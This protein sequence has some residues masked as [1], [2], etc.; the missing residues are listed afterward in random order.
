MTERKSRGSIAWIV[1][2]IVAVICAAAGVLFV[3]SAKSGFAEKEAALPDSAIST[4][5][6]HVKNSDYESIYEDSLQVDPTL[7]SKDDYIAKIKEIYSGTNTDSITYKQVDKQTVT[8]YNL[9]VSDD[10]LATLKL[11]QDSDGKWL[12]STMFEGDTS[13]TVEVPT[14]LSI[15]VNG[16]DVDDS[17]LTAKKVTASNFSGLNDAAGAPKV[18]QYQLSNLLS[19]P[20]ITVPSDS[21]YKTLKDAVS[22]IIYVG[23]DANTADNAVIFTDDA[24]IIS[25]FPA[26]DTSLGSV[27]SI[28]ITASD[29]YSRISTLQNDW[30][31][32]HGTPTYSNLTAENIIQQSDD[33]MVGNVYFDYYATNG[34]VERTWHC[35]YQITFME[36]NGTMKIAG[37]EVNSSLNPND[38]KNYTE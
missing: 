17:Y 28:S 27:A 26:Q 11:S 3:N 33:T 12:A 10:Y 18:D 32:E 2:I 30:F 25:G 14:G 23:K 22:N 35:G 7:N 16:M 15:Q 13:Y 20:V 38:V 21:S 4:Y 9:Y 36:S 1:P 37:I 34:S 6:N 19:D 8:E 24:K 5:L 29:W 31:T